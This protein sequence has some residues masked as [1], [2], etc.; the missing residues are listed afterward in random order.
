MIGYCVKDEG[1]DHF[2]YV[3]FN[4]SP[5]ELRNGIAT[6]LAESKTW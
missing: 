6:H 3:A 2:D 5:L 4:M 1:K